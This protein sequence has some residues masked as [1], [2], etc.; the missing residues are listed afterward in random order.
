MEEE[1]I[2]G[3]FDAA[4]A[5]G[6]PGGLPDVAFASF[7]ESRSSAA[8]APLSLRSEAPNED[9]NEV[10]PLALKLAAEIKAAAASAAAAAARPCAVPLRVSNL[11]QMEL[12]AA[13]GETLISLFANLLQSLDKMLRK[14]QQ[15]KQQLQQQLG[16]DARALWSGVGDGKDFEG[17]FAVGGE[18]DFEGDFPAERK[19]GRSLSIAFLKKTTSMNFSADSKP[20][21]QQICEQLIDKFAARLVKDNS[22]SLPQE[23]QEEFL[24]AWREGTAERLRDQSLSFLQ[25]NSKGPTWTAEG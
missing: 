10:D 17:L 14:V 19:E 20:Q 8:E 2:F 21:V 9:K 24:K 15:Q 13:S 23:T 3:S 7:A 5:S 22:L 11:R 4:G 25:T 6:A 18:G 1:S 16:R 12:E